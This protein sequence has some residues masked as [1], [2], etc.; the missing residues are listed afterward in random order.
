MRTIEFRGKRV[1]NGKF[2][3]GF[4]VKIFDGR[5]FIIPENSGSL[6]KSPYIPYK[7]EVSP[8]TIGQFTGLL[9]KNNKKIYEGDITRIE[10]L[11]GEVHYF[12][13]VIR[14][15]IRKVIN[16]QGFVDHTSK[17]AI[18]GVVFIWNGFEL[19]PCVD[20]EGIADSSNMEVV[21]NI[22]DNHE[23]LKL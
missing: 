3:Y 2:A 9:D 17:V 14:T 12:E 4:L 1:D 13:V 21:G 16:H 19:F 22:H 20:D 7:Y 8:K 10:L 15:V 5:S 18:T 11:S 6:H 23:L